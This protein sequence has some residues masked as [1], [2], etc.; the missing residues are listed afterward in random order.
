MLTWRILYGSL[1]SGPTPY[2]EGSAGAFNYWPY[3]L[4]SVLVSERG[5]VMA[6]HPLFALAIAGLVLSVYKK[7]TFWIIGW[8]GLIGFAAQLYL[9]SSWSIWWAGASFGNRFFIS[10]LP[11]LVFGLI[12]LFVRMSKW[13]G[14]KPVIIG[15]ALLSVWNMGLLLQYFTQMVPRDGEIPW[16]QVV[17]QNCVDIPRY[18]WEKLGSLFFHVTDIFLKQR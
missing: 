18:I 2:L 12:T 16:R 4:I 10:S 8:V 3:H 13:I 9:V 7:D 1:L 5:G 11:F 17:K 6:W 15:V 14:Y